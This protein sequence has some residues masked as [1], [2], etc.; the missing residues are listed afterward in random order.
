MR[1]ILFV[2]SSSCKGG[3]FESLCQYLSAMDRENFRPFLVC[4]NK[5][6]DPERLKSLN[7]P[8]LVAR[9]P[10]YNEDQSIFVRK[11]LDGLS[12]VG[13][14]LVPTLS[15]SLARYIH[16]KTIHTIVKLIEK[17]KVDLVHLNVQ[18]GRDIFG[19][20]AA[21]EAGVR[22][23]THLR[24]VRG[25]LTPHAVCYV[26]RIVDVFVANSEVTQS[27]WLKMGIAPDKMRR[28]PNAIGSK[29]VKAADLSERWNI[30]RKD[31]VVIG[32]I[33]PLHLEK[34]QAFLIKAFAGFLKKHSNSVLIIAGGG[35]NRNVLKQMV[36]ELGLS[37]RII[38]T[39]HVNRAK[40]LCAAFDVSVVPSVYDSFGRVVLESLRVGTP[41]IATDVGAIREIIRTGENGLLVEYGDVN[42]LEVAMA[43]IVEDGFLRQTLVEGGRRTVEGDFGIERYRNRVEKIYRNVFRPAREGS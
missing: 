34:G 12:S 33:S 30:I 2:E 11:I 15:V 13:R 25:S 3:S 10:L 35:P 21:E 22:C 16:R 32:C 39:G 1:N 8:F 36:K 26:N 20:L 4:L 29:P 38:F 24:S 5:P 31:T 23:V 42:A 18:I 37:L 41:L 9:D 19:V 28:I 27:Y 40:E 6:P 17:E 14:R 43:R 7:V